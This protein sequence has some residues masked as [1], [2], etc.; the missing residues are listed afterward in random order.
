[1]IK[2]K[3]QITLFTMIIMSILI[4]QACDT[5]SSSKQNG[6]MPL[7]GEDNDSQDQG[8]PIPPRDESDSDDL[9]DLSIDEMASYQTAPCLVSTAGPTLPNHRSES[10]ETYLDR[11]ASLQIN[12]V[13]SS[14]DLSGLDSFAL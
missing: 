14:Y 11:L 9:V 12:N 1:M 10:D 6:A 7:L 13:P 3:R 2:A 5:Q 8:L 4:I